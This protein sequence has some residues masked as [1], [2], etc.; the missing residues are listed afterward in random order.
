MTA[1]SDCRNGAST[2]SPGLPLSATLGRKVRMSFYRKAVASYQWRN[3]Q[4]V[5]T[6][7]RLKINL[8]LFP[9]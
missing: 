7:L 3:P 1:T 4:K 5:A 9:G 6:A 8:D 2:S